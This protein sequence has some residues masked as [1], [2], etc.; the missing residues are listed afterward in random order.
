MAGSVA[1]ATRPPAGGVAEVPPVPAPPVPKAR[2]LSYKSVLERRAREA[3]AAQRRGAIADRPRSLPP[4]A[5][6]GDEVVPATPR[7]G[8]AR[9]ARGVRSGEI[10]RLAGD[11]RA[12]GTRAKSAGARTLP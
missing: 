9:D 12:E 2:L 3:A 6:R 7:P 5:Q 4:P 1:A 10:E 11:T 8:S